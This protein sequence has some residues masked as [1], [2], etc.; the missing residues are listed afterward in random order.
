MSAR[1][2]HSLLYA[3]CANVLKILEVVLKFHV[4]GF[5][6][7]GINNTKIILNTTILSLGPN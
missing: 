6:C 4:H 5:L 1:Q 7:N 3:G 2:L